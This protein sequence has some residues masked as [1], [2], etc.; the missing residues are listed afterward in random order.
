MGTWR[1]AALRPTARAPRPD[2]ARVIYH[3]PGIRLPGRNVRRVRPTAYAFQARR[4]STRLRWGEK[5]LD[6]RRVGSLV[7][8]TAAKVA[9]M[10]RPRKGDRELVHVPVLPPELFNA[11]NAGACGSNADRG[12][13]V[14]DMMATYFGMPGHV[15]DVETLAALPV[16]WHV[17]AAMLTHANLIGIGLEE[18]TAATLA[19]TLGNPELLSDV[20]GGQQMLAMEATHSQQTKDIPRVPMRVNRA[21]Y[22]VLKEDASAHGAA[23]GR[24]A[25]DMMA[26][27]FGM[28]EHV[29]CVKTLAALPIR[30]PVYDAIMSCADELGLSLLDF[31]TALAAQALG[32]AELADLD[33]GRQGE[34]DIGNERAVA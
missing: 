27:F 9:R 22:D 5:N 26:T 7:S 8:D 16:R 3:C 20:G 10:A 14:A 13:F 24:F 32:L 17:Y 23:M 11:L 25:A 21:V 18:A 2:P 19:Q 33:A 29:V 4:P 31:G 1:A 34:L 6:Y 28:P 15:K 12:P 30:R